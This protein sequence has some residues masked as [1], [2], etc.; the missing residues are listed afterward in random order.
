M[1]DLLAGKVAIITGAGRGIGRSHSIEMA[2]QGAKIVVNDLGAKLDG[3]GASRGP[4]EE[5]VNEIKKM[6][7]EAVA[8]YGSVATSADADSIIKTAMDMFGRVDILVNNAGI[9]R[10]RIIFNMTDDEWDLVIKVHLYGTFYCTRA[11]CRVMK[12]QKYGRIINTSSL[13][14]MGQMGQTNYSAAKEGIVGLTRTV[15]RDMM[16]YN[17]TCNAI[18]P[19][20][21]TRLT[22]TDEL[23]EARKKAVGEEKAVQWKKNLEAAQPEDIT[24]LVVYLASEKAHAVNG[25][26]FDVRSD[27]VARYD[28]PPRLASTIIRKDG[29]WNSE[30]L[31]EVMPKTLVAGLGEPLSATGVKKLAVDARGWEYD[32]KKLTEIPPV[33]K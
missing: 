1:P 15:A 4:A 30:E 10:D 23:F 20:A 3:A 8:N 29:K 22:V 9:L 32:G 5:V 27:F 18:R 21:A 14:G 31:V 2:R 16:R 11:A 28:D 33:L 25:C 7:G 12:E 17:V 6:G 24:P 19:I 13:A 26:V